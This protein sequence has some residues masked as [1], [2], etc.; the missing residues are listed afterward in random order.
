L[1]KLIAYQAVELS[2]GR[3]WAYDVEQLASQIE[4]LGID[5]VEDST[6]KG[7]AISLLNAARDFVPDLLLLLARPKTL[8]ARR[9]VGRPQDLIRG[10][11][12]LV[13]STILSYG[14]L[15]CAWPIRDVSLVG[16]F[17][18]CAFIG[19]FATLV[20]SVPLYFAWWVVGARSA[21]RRVAT[22]LCY[23]SGV[24]TL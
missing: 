17:G 2:E 11:E 22:P 24:V 8:L 21:Y 4:R 7:W 6:P 5:R 12:F 14:L 18:L 20:L 16:F 13:L 19:S 15:L 3:H 1:R 10:L 9:N 23:E